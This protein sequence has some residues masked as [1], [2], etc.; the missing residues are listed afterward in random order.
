MLKLAPSSA[1][2]YASPGMS[3]GRRLFLLALEKLT[4][5]R[6]ANRIYAAWRC[7]RP[8]SSCRA[9]NDLLAACGIALRIQAPQWP[10]ARPDGRRLIIIAN[11]PFGIPDGV[12]IL[13]LAEQLE[14]PVRILINTD[15]L[16]VPEMTRFAL[17]IDF[18][19]TKDA[20]RT[21]M[22]SRKEALACLARGETVVIFPSGGIAT[23]RSPFA[24]AEELPWKRFTA[25]LIHMARADVLPVHF[26]GQNS[27][28]FHAAS[29]ISMFLRLSLIV[30]E[31]VR[32]LGRPI[33]VRIGAVIPY[34]RLAAVTDRQA[35][36][37]LLYEQVMAL[38]AAFRVGARGMGYPACIG[39]GDLAPETPAAG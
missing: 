7:S 13:A 30:P 19:Q 6:R 34:E 26:D 35:L 4:G 33:D 29:R 1:L 16:R 8:D 22:E 38:R 21:N 25:K 17:P 28:L 11:H 32:R 37:R 39:P 14:R 27:P 3:R 5:I 9:M 2:S 24:H 20:L 10:V 31:A 12:A 23:A 18:S 15:L 36:T